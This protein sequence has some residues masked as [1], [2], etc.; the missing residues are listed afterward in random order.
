MFH[1]KLYKKDSKGKTRYW[2]VERNE[3]CYRTIS[4]IENSE[5]P[6]TSEWTVAVGKN[7][8]KSNE[9]SHAE[10]AKL[11][12]E[13]MY[14]KKL[15]TGYSSSVETSG[16]RY[17]EPML[18][19]KWEDEK[20]IIG[21]QPMY[22]QP[23][24]DGFRCVAQHTGLFSRKGEEYLSVPHIASIVQKICFD[25]LVIFDGELYNHDLKDDFN[26]IASVVRK[27]KPSTKELDDSQDLIQYHIYDIIDARLSFNSRYTKL[28]L[29]FDKYPELHKHCRLVETKHF[30][31]QEIMDKLYSSYLSA[32]Y[33][34]QMVR[35]DTRYENKRSKS[36]LKRKEFQDDEFKIVAIEEGIGNRS[37]MA[38]RVTCSLPDGRTFGAGIKGGLDLNKSLWKMKDI[39]IGQ[40]ATI[41]FF[42]YTPDGIPRFPVFKSVRED[43]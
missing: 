19:K 20:L 12:V 25:E 29:L 24:L 8:G 37:N 14:D 22:S 13:A 41:E 28:V 31:N 7:T 21:H 35:L 4:G 26:T 15:K 18:A 32:G 33:E 42:N 1:P 27:K 23:K 11:E 3:N 30:D 43:V 9:T 6:V 34:G 10:Q 40:L 38:G 39:L 16:T 17:I 2:Q 5:S 36:L